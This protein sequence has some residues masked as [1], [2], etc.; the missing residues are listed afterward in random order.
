MTVY[1]FCVLKIEKLKFQFQ[2][3]KFLAKI[4]HFILNSIILMSIKN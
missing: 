1:S 2:Y 3:K 4:K